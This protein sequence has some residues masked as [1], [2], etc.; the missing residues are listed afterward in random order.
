M[1]DKLDQ[2]QDLSAEEN[3]HTIDHRCG[4]SDYH[5]VGVADRE[6]YIDW[7]QKP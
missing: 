6:A 7:L 2:T 3:F 4:H 5:F 1:P